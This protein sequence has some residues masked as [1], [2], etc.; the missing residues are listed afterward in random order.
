MNITEQILT[1]KNVSEDFNLDLTYL[2]I[3]LTKK[4]IQ[5]YLTYTQKDNY[6]INI[7]D[8][9]NNYECVLDEIGYLTYPANIHN[10][11]SDSLAR[12][13]YCYDYKYRGITKK[14]NYYHIPI[15]LYVQNNKLGVSYR[16]GTMLN[17]FGY[18]VQ[19][20]IDKLNDM[21]DNNPN[22]KLHLN[23]K[24]TNLMNKD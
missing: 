19:E 7:E 1:L 20:I 9:L 12:L 4:H 5:G 16:N 2:E 3:K 24:F 22:F 15:E 10:H 11:F 21:C 18:S 17:V 8:Y 13:I 6:T 14:N 23:E